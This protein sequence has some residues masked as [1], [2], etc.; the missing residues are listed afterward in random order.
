MQ[1]QIINQEYYTKHTHRHTQRIGSNLKKIQYFY[2]ITFLGHFTAYCNKT[3]ATLLTTAVIRSSIWLY[4]QQ[5]KSIKINKQK[6]TETKIV[7][8][9][10]NEKYVLNVACI[11]RSY[12]LYVV[13]TLSCYCLHAIN[14]LEWD[15]FNTGKARSALAYSLAVCVLVNRLK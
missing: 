13:L 11:G 3:D 2:F 12:D 8:S 4:A 7:C 15:F 10:H 1:S 6:N 9:Q 14:S 5:L